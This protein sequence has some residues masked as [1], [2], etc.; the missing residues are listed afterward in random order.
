[1]CAAMGV[2]TGSL[3]VPAPQRRKAVQLDTAGFIRGMCRVGGNACCLSSVHSNRATASCDPSPATGL[4]STPCTRWLQIGFQG[5]QPE[6]GEAP[7][8]GRWD[9]TSSPGSLLLGAAGVAASQ[10]NSA[11][12]PGQKQ[13]RAGM[14]GGARTST[15]LAPLPMT[16]FRP[17]F[18]CLLHELFSSDYVFLNPMADVTGGN[19]CH[20][21]AACSKCRV[22]KFQGL[23]CRA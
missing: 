7:E 21:V 13:K 14:G 12:L 17:D 5:W 8:V 15:S 2:V 10:R 20:V 22:P 16:L 9:L 19:F 3:C 23:A 11:L 6:P 4:P 18:V 1:M